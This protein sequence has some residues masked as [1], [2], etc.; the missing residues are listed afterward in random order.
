MFS[1]LRL[2]PQC[3]ETLK[4]KNKHPT[5]IFSSYVSTIISHTEFNFLAAHKTYTTELPMTFSVSTGSTIMFP[6]NIEKENL[7]SVFLI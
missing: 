2:L 6:Y 4:I 3:L 1:E 5:I 7:N